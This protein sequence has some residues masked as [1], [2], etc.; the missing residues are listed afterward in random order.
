MWICFAYLLAAF[1]VT[2]KDWAERTSFEEQYK[3]ILFKLYRR[4]QQ[5][6][7]AIA[8]P[9]SPPAIPGVGTSGGATFILEDRAGKDIS[10]LAANVNKF[11]AA[12]QKRTGA[13][14]VSKL[15]TRGD[16]GT[17]RFV[18]AY[19]TM[20][21]HEPETLALFT[22]YLERYRVSANYDIQLLLLQEMTDQIQIVL[23]L[24]LG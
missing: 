17:L 16:D 1:F 19:P 12:A 11:I 10:F 4:L 22:D 13:R 3:V 5:I 14:A 18:H 2:L 21:P 23:G 20:T 6:P 8:F 24:R 9:F 7:A 15:T